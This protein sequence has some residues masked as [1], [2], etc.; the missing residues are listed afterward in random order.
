MIMFAS[1][2]GKNVCVTYDSDDTN[3][4]SNSNVDDIFNLYSDCEYCSTLP[5]P[6]P[7]V[8]STPSTTPVATASATPS[9]TPT[10][11]QTPTSSLPPGST[12]NPTQS[13]TT[14]LTATPTQTSTLAATP[15]PTPN[16]V[17]V[18]ESCS[19]LGNQI[20]NT[21][22]IQRFNISTVL[23]NRVFQDEFGR[24]WKFIGRFEQNYIAPPTVFAITNSG[25]Y[26]SNLTI[27][28]TYDDCATCQLPPLVNYYELELCEGTFT[29][30]STKI[31]PPDPT[32]SGQLYL[33]PGPVDGI[34]GVIRF[35]YTGV[36][37]QYRYNPINYN[38]SIQKGTDGLTCLS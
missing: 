26:F 23:L 36:V 16:W 18:Y 37:N 30:A 5:T 6:T 2:N 34:Y 1:V 28:E 10:N 29:T 11:T 38:S 17:Y 13:P 12:P 19:P 8:T 35:R 3:I 27:N 22:V 14:T 32:I 21:Q 20:K 31:A 24:C 25:N 33:L 7:T 15:T 4:S 9:N